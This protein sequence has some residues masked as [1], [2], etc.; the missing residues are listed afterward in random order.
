M[1]THQSAN[2]AYQM[3]TDNADR[4]RGERMIKAAGVLTGEAFQTTRKRIQEE[5][6]WA[7]WAAQR[8]L[9]ASNA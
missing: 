1:T 8:T 3:C 4:V 2:V 7:C 5:Y 6:D 9:E